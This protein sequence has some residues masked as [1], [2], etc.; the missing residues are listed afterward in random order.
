MVYVIPL[1]CFV[2]LLIVGAVLLR[3]GRGVIVAV[4]ILLLAALF[5]WAIWKGRQT[6]GW[7][8]SAMRSWPC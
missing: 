1:L 8:G 7:D 4:L 2:I 5:A 3:A 6:T